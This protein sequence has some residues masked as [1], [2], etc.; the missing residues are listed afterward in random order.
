MVLGPLLAGV[1]AWVGGWAH[2][3]AIGPIP[4]RGGAV[5]TAQ[6]WP[7][8]LACA[9]GQAVGLAPA[10]LDTQRRATGGTFQ[11]AVILSG[12]AGLTAVLMLGFLVGVVW[13]S[14]Y[15]VVVVVLLVVPLALLPAVLTEASAG[16]LE[17]GDFGRSYLSVAL[18]WNDFGA[19]AGQREVTSSALARLVLFSLFALSALMAARIALEGFGQP[20]LTVA[21]RAAAVW[22]VPLAV[23]AALI[24][25]Q[26][27]L[28]EALGQTSC[29]TTHSVQICVS[30]DMRTVLPTLTAGAGAVVG[31]FGS[32]AMTDRVA[33]GVPLSHT[34]GFWLWAPTA[35]A[36]RE[37]AA[38]A[39][40][41]AISGMN[42]CAAAL[43]NQTRPGF[44]DG[45]NRR[46]EF[47]AA[48]AQEIARRT[49]QV[50][51]DALDAVG[52]SPD[53]PTARVLARLPDADLRAA[54]ERNG[55]AL[56]TCSAGAEALT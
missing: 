27:P 14:R 26:P 33:Q 1:A 51:P 5:L 47:T 56:S 40:A 20:R 55:K 2:T 21:R 36:S 10:V 12:M 9:A 42:D 34:A 52:P 50:S 43:G 29:R 35:R 28:I 48:L 6:A 3:A 11:P 15:A 19:Q 30:S 23:A 13:R 24:A 46:F 18:V 45:L 38:I 39:A 41:R 54:L 8:A 32:G 31:Q 17:S 49:G 22:L 7:L 44:D 25:R 37:A 16:R 53:G 4:A